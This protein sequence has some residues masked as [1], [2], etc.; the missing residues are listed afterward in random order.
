MYIDE[1]I[2]VCTCGGFLSCVLGSVSNNQS[3][4][5]YYATVAALAFTT[6]KLGLLL[7]SFDV[8]NTTVE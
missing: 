5:D 7:F 4:L 6:R 1:C 3:T 2:K 8:R